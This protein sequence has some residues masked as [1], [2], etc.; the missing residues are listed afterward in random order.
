[1][2]Y[3]NAISFQFFLLLKGLKETTESVNRIAD[4]NGFLI[5]AIRTELNQ[6][7]ERLARKKYDDSDDSVER[8][9]RFL[10]EL[11]KLGDGMSMALNDLSSG[12]YSELKTKQV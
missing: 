5:D 7:C 9:N 4:Q 3:S 6:V 11:D 10:I 1:M 2:A 8:E 12:V